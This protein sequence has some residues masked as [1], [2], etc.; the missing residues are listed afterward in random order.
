MRVVLR[1]TEGRGGEEPPSLEG[2]KW[3]E[4]SCREQVTLVTAVDCCSV[5]VRQA[6]TKHL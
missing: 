2:E 5:T 3:E 4:Q 6:P 1:K